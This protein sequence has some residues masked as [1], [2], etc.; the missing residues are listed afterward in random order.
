MARK[1][2]KAV[3]VVGAEIVPLLRF[4]FRNDDPT[5]PPRVSG[6]R[7]F[8]CGVTESYDAY[9]ASA[10]PDVNAVDVDIGQGPIQRIERMR[11][12]IFSAEQAFL[13]SG[14]GE[15]QNRSLRSDFSERLG[16]FE[17]CSAAGRVVDGTVVDLIALQFRIAA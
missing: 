15:K 16:Q 9:V 10:T 7:I 8:K 3:P 13:F 5:L 14:H 4:G 17:Q 12:V 11:G 1:Y 2:Q 6:Q